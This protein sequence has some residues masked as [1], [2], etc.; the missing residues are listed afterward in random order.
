MLGSVHEVH[1]AIYSA[2]PFDPIPNWILIET[3]KLIISKLL[4]SSKYF[5]LFSLPELL[6]DL[7]IY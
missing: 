6:R 2:A 4:K 1:T 3:I 7:G 5:K